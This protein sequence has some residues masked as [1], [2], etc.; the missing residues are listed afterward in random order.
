MKIDN[1]QAKELALITSIIIQEDMLGGTIFQTFDQAF[2]LAQKWYHKN[3]KHNIKWDK[4]ELDY[5]EAII[6]FVNNELQKK[7]ESNTKI[8]SNEKNDIVYNPSGPY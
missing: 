5:D 4:Q 3:A 8:K 7:K 6:I 2:N 1:E